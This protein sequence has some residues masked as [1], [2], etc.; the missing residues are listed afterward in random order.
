VT[1]S[2][3]QPALWLA[4]LLAAVPALADEPAGRPHREGPAPPTI[5]VT[6]AMLDRGQVIYESRCT[7][8][9]GGDG[10]GLV[11]GGQGPEMTPPDLRDAGFMATRSDPE[12]ANIIQYGGFRMPAFP[13]VRGDDLVAL[14]ARIRS[15]SWPQVRSV[16]LQLL[17]QG[18]VENFSPV[19]GAMLENPP[20]EDWLMF[21][22]TYDGWGYSPLDQV[23]RDNVGELRLAW[24]RAME[25]GGQYTTPLVYAGTLYVQHPGDV[26]QALDATNG[27]LIWEYRRHREDDSRSR[28]RRNLAIYEHRLFHLTDDN[29]LIA[30]DARDGALLW[31]TEEQGSNAGI[32]HMGGP[33]VAAGIVVSGRSCSPRGGPDIC[34]L[35]GHDPETGRELW[36]RRTIP[37]PGEPGDDSWGDV[38]DERRW[39]V[40][41]WGNVPSYDPVLGLLYWGTSVP[42]PSLEQLRGTSGRD[43]LYSNS[44]L[45]TRPS[46][47]EVVWYYQHLP[48]DNWDL[49]HVF[50]RYLVD[51]EVTPDPAEVPWI[52]KSVT[53]GERRRVVTG[54][55][56]KTGIVYTLDRETGEFLWARETLHQ[57][58]VT[59]IDSKGGVHI[60]E[61][62][63]VGPFEEILVCP[64]LGGGKNWPAGSYSP[65]TGLMYQPQQNM[66]VLQTGNTETPEA[67]DG[68]ATSWIVVPDP[69][70]TGDPYPVGRIDA[71]DV[72]T[73][74]Q[75]WRHEQRAAVI[76]TSVSTAGGLLFVGDINRRFMALDDSTGEVLWQTIVSAPVSGSAVSY[77]VGGRQY[78]AVAVGGGTA[79]PE[80]RAL[81]VH[82]EL[83]PPSNSP[84]LFVF[85]LPSAASQH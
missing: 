33:M 26:I 76:G 50:E 22:R 52:S 62:L 65:L 77:A 67:E 30:L 81:S 18:T 46:T 66:C 7:V 13:Q 60:N 15:L 57:N 71:I 74:R 48:R 8:C 20:D 31:E 28:N 69:A 27:D 59:S 83:K 35:A 3:R 72:S 19:T 55:P 41:S 63:V 4:S 9:H 25:P 80:R 43:V 36:Q 37:K 34:Y 12:I 2:P 17:A 40:G 79:S 56:G 24:S 64:S 11:V 54:I 78:I 42:A 73:G 45:A 85:A 53:P 10:A 61:D 14:V 29:H 6:A 5:S 47:G 82:T 51:V 58:V 49:D 39:H 21:R 32:G 1:F 84:A 70:V 44:T 38:P 16:D 68:Y 75:A 23:N